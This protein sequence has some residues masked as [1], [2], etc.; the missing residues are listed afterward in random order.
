MAP[1]VRDAV[2]RP[3]RSTTNVWLEKGASVCGTAETVKVTPAPVADAVPESMI[4]IEFPV[5]LK[6]VEGAD[7]VDVT[8]SGLLKNE[9]PL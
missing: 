6:V 4:E 5:D 3:T 9:G 2:P 8:R 7:E 1:L